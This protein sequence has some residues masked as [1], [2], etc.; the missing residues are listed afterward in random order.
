M[1]YHKKKNK[2]IKNKIKKKRKEKRKQNPSFLKLDGWYYLDGLLQIRIS[3][4]M[5]GV[6]DFVRTIRDDD[7]GN[8]D[9]KKDNENTSLNKVASLRVARKLGTA[10]A[11]AA[12][13][14]SKD[15]SKQRK[16]RISDDDDDDNDDEDDDDGDLLATDFL[17]D[18]TSAPP[19]AWDLKKAKQNAQT[20]VVD[21]MV[22]KT[23]ALVVV[24]LCSMSLSFSLHRRL[25]TD[26]D[27]C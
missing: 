9:N 20:A 15:K 2:E 18:A 12:A 7:D 17:F 13:A 10:S 25:I 22:W 4:R 11:T 21:G 23:A 27:R 1:I 26:V 8:D 24:S 3:H 6:L 16:R 19:V 5:S 14:T